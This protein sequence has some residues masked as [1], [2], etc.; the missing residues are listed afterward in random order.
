MLCSARASG[1]CRY[2]EAR[3]CKRPTTEHILRLFS[4]AQRSTIVVD[5]EPVKTFDPELTALQL[6]VL[7]L[8]DVPVTRYRRRSWPHRLRRPK[9]GSIALGEVRNVGRSGR[10]SAIDDKVVRRVLK[11]TTQRIPQ[12]ATHWS[13]RL[14]AEYAQVSTWQVRQIWKA[15]CKDVQ[16]DG[17]QLTE[18]GESI[19]GVDSTN[20][21][22]PPVPM[23]SAAVTTPRS[24]APAHPP[25][26]PGRPRSS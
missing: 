9:F 17:Q 4:L 16:C 24:T 13:I 26:H 22:R 2:P 19:V 5:G 6:E 1:N 12:E 14:M 7:R 25:A 8:L 10:P 11:L 3:A 20:G 18:V 23:M 15:A 21:T